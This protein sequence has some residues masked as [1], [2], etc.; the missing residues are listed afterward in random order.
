MCK[1]SVIE[2][3]FNVNATVFSSRFMI[4]KRLNIKDDASELFRVMEAITF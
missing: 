3:N 4:N 2:C 1:M